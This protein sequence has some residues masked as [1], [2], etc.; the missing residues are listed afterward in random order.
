M[1]TDNVNDPHDYW[2]WADEEFFQAQPVPAG[3]RQVDANQPPEDAFDFYGELEDDEQWIVDA[4]TGIVGPNLT[5]SPAVY[6]D[7]FDYSDDESYVSSVIPSG[8]RQLDVTIAASTNL[9]D[10]FAPYLDE[11]LEDFWHDHFGQEEEPDNPLTDPWDPFVGLDDDTFDDV[12][13]LDDFQ[14]VDYFPPGPQ[15]F[16]EPFDQ[17]AQDEDSNWIEE[18]SQ[19][20]AVG[21]DNQPYVQVFDDPWNWDDEPVDDD[22]QDFIPEPVGPDFVPPP[23]FDDPWDFYGELEDDEE[24]INEASQS[25]PVGTDYIPP[26]SQLFEDPFNFDDETG[27]DDLTPFIG[28]EPV[29]LDGLRLIP[30]VDPLPIPVVGGAGAN[31]I[32]DKKKRIYVPFDQ[33]LRN[34]RRAELQAAVEQLRAELEGK[35]A[36]ERIA[37]QLTEDDDEEA[38]AFLIEQYEADLRSVLAALLE[39]L[40]EED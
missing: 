38:V 36:R 32:W 30:L 37:S 1:S 22:L 34:K 35:K 5:V 21:P 25:G 2:Y 23:I 9:V 6:D 28:L 24:W 4:S 40:G 17:D 19:S 11:D 13:V 14:S 27:D 7:P 39:I 3:Y 12:L 10:E 18:A 26:P 29:G 33:W 15:F 20:A 31:Y 8:Y 16:E